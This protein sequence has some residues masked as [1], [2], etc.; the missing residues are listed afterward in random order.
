VWKRGSAPLGRGGGL[1]RRA[2][3]QTVH[4]VVEFIFTTGDESKRD[5]LTLRDQDE[6]A[7]AH[8]EFIADGLDEISAQQL[9]PF[10][11]QRIRF[12]IGFEAFGVASSVSGP[13]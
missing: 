12:A 8:G 11:L 7:L 9:P 13:R 10:N 4:Q 6:R 3:M 5:D 1:S 2:E